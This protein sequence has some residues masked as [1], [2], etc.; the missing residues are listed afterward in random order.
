MRLFTTLQA[1]FAVRG[2]GHNSNPGFGSVGQQ[3]ILLDLSAINQITLDDDKSIASIGPGSTWDA[4]YGALEEFD[5]TGAGGRSA[6]VGVGGLLLGGLTSPSFSVRHF[7]AR[8][9]LVT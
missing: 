5:L 9:R 1:T 7:F 4:V 6:N 3:G 2:A 8:L